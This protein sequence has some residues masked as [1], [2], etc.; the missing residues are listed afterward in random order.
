[1]PILR[2]A[3]AGYIVVTMIEG[4]PHYAYD[5]GSYVSLQACCGDGGRVHFERLVSKWCALTR[6]NFSL[7]S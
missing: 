5:D 7:K 2:R 4:K 1:M 3:A 6:T